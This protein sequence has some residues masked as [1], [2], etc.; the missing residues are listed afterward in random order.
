MANAI[1]VTWMNV[2]PT[3]ANAAGISTIAAGAPRRASACATTTA[4]IKRTSVESVPLTS[5]A[6][7]GT[8][9]AVSKYVKLYCPSYRASAIAWPPSP[10]SH[11]ICA[12]GPVATRPIATSAPVPT[13]IAMRAL[14]TTNAVA[15]TTNRPMWGSTRVSGATAPASRAR[16]AASAAA[17]TAMKNNS[18]AA[19][20]PYR[21]VDR[22]IAGASAPNIK[23]HGSANVRVS[24][25]IEQPSAA[26]ASVM[27]TAAA[28]GNGKRDSASNAA[29]S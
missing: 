7:T 28:S 14:G 27:N 15:S 1:W 22:P 21:N 3:T 6:G 29:A 8:P 16:P 10:V 24:S 19:I 17:L 5:A 2:P 9:T 26:N 20:W 18:N 23:L 4:A 12:A 11:V 13:A 25:T